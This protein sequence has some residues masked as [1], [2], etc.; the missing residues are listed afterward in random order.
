MPDTKKFQFSLKHLLIGI[1]IF[2][3]LTYGV[4]YLHE[5][6]LIEDGRYQITVDYSR[7][8]EEMIAAGKYD[9]VHPDITSSNFP[10]DQSKS[11]STEN[12]EAVIVHLD[13]YVKDTEIVLKLMDK[14]GLRP[15]TLPEL[16]ALG[17][18][19][20]EFQRK[21]WIYALGSRWQNSN[22][23]RG[24]VVLLGDLAYRGP[25]LDS[26]Q[27]WWFRSSRFLAFRK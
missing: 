26:R 17:E 6:H 14:N 5:P 9:W 8:L 2:C 21:Y 13:K 7:T 12:L 27:C 10:I 4:V 3:A 23:H 1:I 24:V 18:Q 15:A 25:D 19:Y 11:G 16:L 22:G 20:P